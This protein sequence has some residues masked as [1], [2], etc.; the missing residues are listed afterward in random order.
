MLYVKDLRLENIVKMK[1]TF[2]FQ[3]TVFTTLIDV[4]KGHY[5]SYLR[6]CPDPCIGW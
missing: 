5:E 3:L 1:I 6:D 2:S 4:A